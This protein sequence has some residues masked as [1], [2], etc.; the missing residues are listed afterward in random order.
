MPTPPSV[1]LRVALIT[2]RYQYRLPVGLEEPS[3]RANVGLPPGHPTLPSLVEK[4]G[5]WNDAY[6]QSGI[7]A[8]FPSF[9]P[10]KSGYD[11]FYGFRGG[12]V[13]YYTHASPNEQEDLWDEDVPVHQTGYLTDLLGSRAMDVVNGYAK[14]G[15]PFLMSLHFSAPHWPWEAP[16]D[17]AESIRLQSAREPGG[18]RRRNAENL[19]A[20][21]SGDGS[22]R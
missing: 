2:G 20:H 1:P 22:Y 6:R 10:L 12:A 11:H 3:G 19:S 5:L 14:S 17:Q 7:W 18:F 16:G 4:G 21:D 9:G 8:V 15:R 13:D